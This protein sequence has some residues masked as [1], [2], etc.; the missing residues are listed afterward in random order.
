[1]TI[2]IKETINKIDR[3]EEILLLYNLLEL[4]SK[5][6]YTKGEKIEI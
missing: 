2:D 6:L 3:K 4:I 5:H 1:M